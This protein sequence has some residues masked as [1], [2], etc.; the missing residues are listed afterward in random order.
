MNN[1]IENI[2][3]QAQARL[4]SD[5][6]T[7]AM[8]LFEQAL[9]IDPDST[10]ALFGAGSGHMKAGQFDAALAF[11]LKARDLEPE[12]VDIAYNL[13]RCHA[14][15]GDRYAALLELQRATQYCRDDPIFCPAIADLLVKLGESKGA[16]ELLAR[17]PQLTPTDQILLARAQSLGGNLQEAVQLLFRLS[18]EVPRDALVAKELATTAANLRDYSVAIMAFERYLKAST[19]KAADYLRFA[20]LLFLS[21]QTDRCEQA[22]KLA[23]DHGE[24]GAELYALRSKIARLKG[25]YE[26]AIQTSRQAIKRFERQGQ[27]WSI[28]AELAPDE[29]V[30]S[31]I[32][33]LQA[34]VSQAP[35]AAGVNHHYE[36]LLRYAL[37]H[38]HERLEQY[39]ASVSALRDA[40]LIQKAQFMERNAAYQRDNTEQ[41]IDDLIKNYGSDVIDLPSATP[42]QDGNS[43]APIFIVGMPRSGTTLVERILGQSNQVTMGGELETMQL[44]ATEYTKQVGLGKLPKPAKMNEQQWQGLRSAY[45]D[46]K[47]EPC[48]AFLTDKLPHNFLNVGLILKLFPEAKIIQLR[49][50]L[51]D[52]CLSIY[53]QPFAQGHSYACDLQDCEHFY[54]QA[55]RLMTHWNGL[56][57]PQLFNLQ[58]ENLVRQ[59]DYYAQQLV[60]FCG[61]KWQPHYLDFHQNISPSFTFSEMA[62]RQP[63]TAERIN[64]WQ[65]FQAY[66]PELSG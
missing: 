27:A 13:A 66:L 15:T 2:L 38:L 56:H 9:E 63:I 49:R 64:R 25:D 20:D 53:S 35:A 10:A 36:A 59:P 30:E 43:P 5:D 6:V 3:S 1:D 26:L 23:I 51:Q 11:F 8:Q 52:V 29:D 34:L 54:Q 37:A 14:E 58:Y 16:I 33:N 42:G 32:Q 55:E 31:L 21:Q 19:P 44:I 48:K 47:P 61:L 60:E 46:K 28:L 57:S 7:E 12:A 18:E 50:N 22:I 39:E 17:L 41:R 4:E 62:V 65:A 45:L 40:N 24:D